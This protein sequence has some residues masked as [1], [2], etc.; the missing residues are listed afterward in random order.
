MGKGFILRGAAG[1]RPGPSGWGFPM[2]HLGAWR[3]HRAQRQPAPVPNTTSAPCCPSGAWWRSAPMSSPSL[4]PWCLPGAQWRPVPAPGTDC[5]GAGELARAKHP[6]GAVAAVPR[7]TPARPWVSPVPRPLGTVSPSR[8]GK[9]FRAAHHREAVA[10]ARCALAARAHADRHPGAVV[11][12]VC[13]VAASVRAERHLEAPRR[14]AR[15]RARAGAPD[16]ALA[17]ARYPSPGR[18]RARQCCAGASAA[19]G[20]PEGF[21]PNAASA[22][23]PSAQHSRR[24]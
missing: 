21:K 9:A 8:L 15:R 14:C 7:R 11:P 22:D 3:L 24:P 2:R 4:G 17:P 20:V 6:R 16:L 10:P 23:M 12:T 13:V 1:P 18:E 5:P 19:A